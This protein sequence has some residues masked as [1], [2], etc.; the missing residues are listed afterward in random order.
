MKITKLQ[1]TSLVVSLLFLSGI[2]N[3]EYKQYNNTKQDT[4]QEKMEKRQQKMEERQQKRQDKKE[5]MKMK[6]KGMKQK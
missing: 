4:K 1:M 5:E 6:Q 3:A 2:A